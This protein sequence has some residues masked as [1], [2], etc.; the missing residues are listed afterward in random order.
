M[1]SIATGVSS[2]KYI[3]RMATE[4]ENKFDGLKV[5]IYEIKNNYFG[6]NVTVTG[7]LTGIDLIEQL[8]GKELGAELLISRSMLKADE[9]IL[10][11]DYSIK[12]LEE[13]INIKII[14]VEND[15]KDFID[16]ILKNNEN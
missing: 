5:N 10:L 12:M 14:V 13:A 6:K 4:L 15:G 2:Y 11:D 9:E 16:K 8:R 7:L 3:K 1:V